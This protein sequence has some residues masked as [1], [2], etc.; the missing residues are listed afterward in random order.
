[1][2]ARNPQSKNIHISLVVFLNNQKSGAWGVRRHTHQQPKCSSGITVA[3]TRNLV[4]KMQSK[5]KIYMQMN[6]SDIK[7]FIF[8][9]HG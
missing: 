2:N 9:P 4:Y 8:S 1:M 3:H 5:R 6:K 7:L